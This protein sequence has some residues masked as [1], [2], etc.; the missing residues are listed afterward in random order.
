MTRRRPSRGTQ[1]ALFAGCGE[2]PSLTSRARALATRHA[3]L[4]GKV[5]P[6]SSCAG[7]S[8]ASVKGYKAALESGVEVEE[9]EDLLSEVF[10]GPEDPHGPAW[11]R[12]RWISGASLLKISASGNV[13][14]DSIRASVA[15]SRANGQSTDR[16]RRD[17]AEVVA[18][19][20]RQKG[21]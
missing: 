13:K 17:I 7:V 5:L 20:Q 15:R 11:W 3:R 9:I 4:V 21:G 2:T 14:I 18:D 6:R 19:M 12:T 8:E 10:E 1:Q 16:I